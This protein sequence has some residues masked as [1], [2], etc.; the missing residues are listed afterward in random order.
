M[1]NLLRANLSRLRRDRVF[2]ACAAVTMACAM[3]L[4]IAWCLDDLSRGLEENL[5]YYYFRLVL[6]LGLFQSVFACLFLNVEYSEGTVRNKLAVGHTRC[7]IYLANFLA[8]L[9]GSM[10]ILLAWAVGS[11]V[12]IPLVGIWKFGFPGL[13]LYLLLTA[14]FSIVFAALMT[15]IG[16]LNTGRSAIVVTLLAWLVLLMAA[17]TVYNNLSEPEFVGGFTVTVDGMQTVKPEPNPHYVTGTA[18]AVY[19]FFYDL[20]PTGQAAQVQSAAVARPVRALVCDAVLTLGFT[21]GGLA[22]FRKKDLK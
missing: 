15:F 17:S 4:M 11:C 20:L 14:A 21:L 16:V 7:E 19:E 3:G 10:V 8:V 18:R 22:L 9:I 5:E 2:W 1:T 6:A 13:G 12:G